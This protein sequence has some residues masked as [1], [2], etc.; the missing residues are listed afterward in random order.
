[1][2]NPR[3][4]S[5]YL[6][7]ALC[8]AGLLSLAAPA[9]T[10]S[11]ADDKGGAVQ[12]PDGG[13]SNG[14]P[15]G[16]G[17]AENLPIEQTI[18]DDNVGSAEADIARAME[19]CDDSLVSITI[20]ASNSSQYGTVASYG[21]S[22]TPKS[23]AAMVTLATGSISASSDKDQGEVGGL[24]AHPQPLPNPSDGCGTADPSQ[25]LDM[26]KVELQLKAPLGANGFQF[27]FNFLS[28][29]FPEFHCTEFDD[30]FLAV[31]QS[32]GVSGNI[33]FDENNNV[34]SINTGFFDVCD[35]S[36]GL[37]CT[38]DSQ[39]S[40]TGYEGRGG[41]GWLTTTAPIVGGEEFSLTFYLFDEG[42]PVL[43]S[44][45]LLDNFKWIGEEVD[46]D[47]ITID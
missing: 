38:G 36:Y 15:D 26:V 31:L 14:L 24:A 5:S 4:S 33:S 30:T 47:P 3:F 13:S 6:W 18:C 25:V 46:D 27:D 17:A 43:T 20:S 44:Q 37:G 7:Q 16:G 12:G 41:T 10:T 19:L 34:I 11:I 45:V 9:C 1:M 32:S 21:Q 2:S 35:S 40:G 39:L 29:E 23:G 8:V 28:A 22:Y 42:D